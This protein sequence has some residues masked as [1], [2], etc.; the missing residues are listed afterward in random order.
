M[1]TSTDLR[2]IPSPNKLDIF[3]L[4]ISLF[5]FRVKYSIIRISL[6]VRLIPILFLERAFNLGSNSKS[7]K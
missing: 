6:D 7:P 5:K 3:S 2:L 1:V 4:D